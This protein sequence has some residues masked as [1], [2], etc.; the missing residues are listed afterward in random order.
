MVAEINELIVD[1]APE[2]TNQEPQA[3]TV[4]WLLISIIKVSPPCPMLVP[5]ASLAVTVTVYVVNAMM[6][7]ETPVPETTELAA[8]VTPTNLRSDS[9]IKQVIL[10][11]D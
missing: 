5:D 3:S 9:W 7:P 4:H 8:L 1:F 10:I 11:F 6:F 2:F